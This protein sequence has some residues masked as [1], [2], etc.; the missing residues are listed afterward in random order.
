MHDRAADPIGAATSVTAANT[1]IMIL[2]SI[3]A[4]IAQVRLPVEGM[5]SALH[6]LAEKDPRR[7]SPTRVSFHFSLSYFLQHLLEQH[8]PLPLQ[9][10]AAG[11]A[12]VAVPINA[13]KV[14]NKRRYF[15]KSSS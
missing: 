2:L 15:I 1:E 7:M 14:A 5:R 3:E 9:Q 11:D 8:F 12:A 13:A 10:S 4:G 6:Q